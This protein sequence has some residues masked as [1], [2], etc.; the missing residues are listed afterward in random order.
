[1]RGCSRLNHTERLQALLRTLFQLD[2]ADLDFGL[3]RLF[4]LRRTEIEEFIS[5][6]LPREVDEAFAAVSAEE[7]QQLEEELEDI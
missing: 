3:Y 1:M 2:L 7:K 6:Q 4:H 5:E